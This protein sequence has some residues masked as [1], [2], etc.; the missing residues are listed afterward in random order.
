M[1]YKNHLVAFIDILGFSKI[2]IKSKDD[3]KKRN[4]IQ[5]I[6]S[7]CDDITT[8]L[9]GINGKEEINS[10]IVSDSI[11]LSLVIKDESPTISEV[12]NF[13][14][15]AGRLQYGLGEF[16]FMVRGGISF[17]PLYINLEQKQVVGPALIHA[18]NLEKNNAKYPRIIA[19]TSLVKAMNYESIDEFR[20]KIN[21][22]DG[23]SEYK[24]LF[25]WEKDS[26]KRTEEINIPKD[27]P[28]IINFLPTIKDKYPLSIAGHVSQGLKDDITYYDKYRWIADYILHDHYKKYGQG[29]SI[30]IELKRLLS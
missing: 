20:N 16:G 12:Q 6:F 25:E 8:S 10:I 5:K 27:V 19:D 15:A 30:A 22:V 13:F 11:V 7:L 4:D 18:V 14:I 9:R 29:G 24:P 21:S 2:C 1:D 26:L 3:V 17:G 28:L 23:N